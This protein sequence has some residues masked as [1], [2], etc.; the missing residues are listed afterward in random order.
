MESQSASP[1][2]QFGVISVRLFSYLSVSPVSNDMMYPC[3]GDWY[4]ASPE[5]MPHIS[6]VYKSKFGKVHPAMK[7][8]GKRSKDKDSSNPSSEDKSDH[9]DGAG[10][11]SSSAS[12]ASPSS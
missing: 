1:I 9:Q 12:S 5:L 8:K 7:K 10:Q 2:C 4:I 11:G 3:A 6:A